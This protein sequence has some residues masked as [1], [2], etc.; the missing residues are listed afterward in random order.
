MKVISY[1]T[2]SVLQSKSSVLMAGRRRRGYCRWDDCG[3][4]CP[5]DEDDCDCHCAFD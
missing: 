3:P 4:F 5:C 1:G 2:P